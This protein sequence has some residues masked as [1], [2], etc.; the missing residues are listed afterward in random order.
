MTHVAGSALYA[1]DTSPTDLQK[2]R[3]LCAAA[4]GAGPSSSVNLAP[5]ASGAAGA[6]PLIAAA[7]KPPQAG[8]IQPNIHQPPPALPPFPP[9]IQVSLSHI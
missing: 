9:A 4:A 8:I 7:A 2:Y 6:P 1:S 3:Q 5:S